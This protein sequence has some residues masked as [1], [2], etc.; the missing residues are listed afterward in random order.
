MTPSASGYLLAWE[1]GSAGKAVYLHATDK[2]G[3]GTGAGVTIA[4]TTA[5]QARPIVSRAPGGYAVTWMDQV[6]GAQAVQVALVDANLAVTGPTRVA[7]SSGGAGWPW[8]AGTDQR[9]AIL[10]SD[11]RAGHFDTRFADLDA[12][13]AMSNDEPLRMGVPNDALLGRMITTSFGY[14]A[15]WE[16]MRGDDNQIFMALVDPHGMTLGGGLVEE[17]D[18]GDAN[19]PNMAYDGSSAAIV[20]YQWRDGGPQIFMSF[21]DATGKRVGGLHDL[22][23]SQTPRGTARYPDV[24]WTGSEFGVAWIDTR[25]GAAQLYF[26]R[27]KCAR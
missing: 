24:Q 25:D 16:D 13:L 6:L 23:V 4:S 14:L 18:S 12:R 11:H 27:V 7:P 10:W 21:V 9:A 19:W 22:Q 8:V 1:E 26:A 20:Y 15:A 17:P 2:Q 3:A 5:T